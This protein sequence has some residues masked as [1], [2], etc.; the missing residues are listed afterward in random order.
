[1]DTTRKGKTMTY[2]TM[3]D[4]ISDPTSNISK[5]LTEWKAIQADNM[6]CVDSLIAQGMTGEQAWAEA[7]KT[8]RPMRPRS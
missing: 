8:T 6:R 2:K 4:A 3:G 5:R 7:L 1:M